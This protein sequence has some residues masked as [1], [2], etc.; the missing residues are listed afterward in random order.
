MTL[1]DKRGKIPYM[2]KGVIKDSERRSLLWIIWVGPNAYDECPHK[3]I[4][5]RVRHR[6]IC[7]QK[8]RLPR[9]QRLSGVAT[10]QE[11][12]RRREQILLE[13]LQRECGPSSTLI[14]DF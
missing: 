2:A 13:S 12:E 3:D 5:M 6:D 14:S 7:R 9:K 1:Y 10:S 4:L 11:A 8:R